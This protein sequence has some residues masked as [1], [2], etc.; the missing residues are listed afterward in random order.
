MS[1]S[2]FDIYILTE[3]N[4]SIENDVVLIARYYYRRFCK[5]Y[6][7]GSYILPQISKFKK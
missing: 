5:I 2:V 6:I 3:N 1:S 4:T 7:P